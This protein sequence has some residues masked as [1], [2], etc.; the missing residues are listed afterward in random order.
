MRYNSPFYLDLERLV[1]ATIAINGFGRIGRA[2]ARI[3]CKS[4]AHKLIAVNDLA[5][6][7]TLIYLF[8]R[9]SVHRGF[10]ADVS[11]VRF[12]S[13][14]TPIACDFSGAEVV[15]DCSG[16]FT[17]YDE[18]KPYLD[19]GAKRVIISTPSADRA[20]AIAPPLS[21][22]I[23]EVISAGSCTANAL[24]A[25]ASVLDDRFGVKGILATSIH[26]YTSDQRLLDA[27]RVERRRGRASAIN[28]IPVVTSAA[29]NLIRYDPRYQNRA[30]AI[31]LRV[32][33]ADVSLMHAIFLFEQA[34][35][36]EAIN[37]AYDNAQ[38]AALVF[39]RE[40]KVSADIID[41][42][43]S[44]IVD[45]SLTVCCQNLASVGAWHDN[46][47][48]FASRMLELAQI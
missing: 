25:L 6:R 4:R 24:Y 14:P 1:L 28:I 5:D 39:S 36:K 48:G 17:Q 11:D 26:G 45:A 19:R 21:K 40:P 8:E 32:P 42:A 35:D 38:N 23:A 18:L 13:A 29:K 15:L 44:A 33:T 37:A 10:K 7:Q 31:G 12:S 20:V 9:D 46:E 2:C 22:P 47:T 3:I 30:A 41:D 27:R 34:V 43:A 16:V